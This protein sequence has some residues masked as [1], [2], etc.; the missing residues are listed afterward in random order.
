MISNV[1]LILLLSVS[2]VCNI[3]LVWYVRRLIRFVD[4]NALDM[5]AVKTDIKNYE[6][7]LERVYGLELF[8]GDETLKGLLDHTKDIKEDMN[9][10][11]NNTD[12]TLK[13]RVVTT[14]EDND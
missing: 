12:E 9:N 13:S 1:I 3:L 2:L 14:G 4:Y 8:Y 10:F 11:I 5:E 6:Q 7:H